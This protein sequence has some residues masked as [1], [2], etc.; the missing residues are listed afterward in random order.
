MNAVATTLR[1]PAGRTVINDTG[2]A[3]T[4]EFTLEF[5][6]PADTA[7]DRPSIFTALGELGLQLEASTAL[8]DVLIVES[9]HRPTD[10]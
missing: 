5:A 1:I 8:L 6:P 10:N 4:W 3:G 2:L 9:I 7:S